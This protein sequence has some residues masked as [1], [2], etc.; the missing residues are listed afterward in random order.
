MLPLFFRS[1]QREIELVAT[2]ISLNALLLTNLMVRHKNILLSFS[3][4]TRGGENEDDR[5][6]QI[7][8]IKKVRFNDFSK[9][10]FKKIRYKNS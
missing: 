5:V 7:E 6:R 3:E 1:R 9:E 10:F 4:M 8:W 2:L